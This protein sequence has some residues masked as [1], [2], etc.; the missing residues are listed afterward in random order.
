MLLL[1]RAGPS[2]RLLAPLF[3]RSVADSGH[4]PILV[5]VLGGLWGVFKDPCRAR[6]CFYAKQAE[7]LET[8]GLMLEYMEKCP[9]IFA[10]MQ[11][12]P[13][14]HQHKQMKLEGGGL[15]HINDDM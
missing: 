15:H 7:H 10:P 2:D 8:A 3:P 5:V 6:G 13:I 14:V 12:T 11:G 1:L 9:H 4:W